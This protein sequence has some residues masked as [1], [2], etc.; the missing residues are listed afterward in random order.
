MSDRRAQKAER[1]SGMLAD[2]GPFT[3]EAIP[4]RCAPKQFDW[5]TSRM[6]GRELP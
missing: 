4:S 2:H 5:A 3:I 6:H 1:V